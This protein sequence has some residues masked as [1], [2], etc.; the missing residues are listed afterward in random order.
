MLEEII[1]TNPA[2]QKI[3]DSLPTLSK[4][5]SPLV[6]IG[7]AGV[8]KSFFALHIHA[9]SRFKHQPHEYMNFSI[10]SDRIQRI[11]LFGAEPPE[12]TTHRRGILE[13]TSTV[14]LKHINCANPYLQNRLADSIQSMTTTRFGSKEALPVLCR[15]IFTF[16]NSLSAL[17]KKGE[18]TQT[19]FDVLSKCKTFHIP[20]L[21]DRK[22]DIPI[23]SE[24]FLKKFYNQLFSK[25]NGQAPIIR[26]LDNKKHLEPR[27][28]ETLINHAWQDNIRDLMAFLRNMLI[29]PYEYELHQTEKLEVMKMLIMM[30]N[31]NEF[32]LPN[33]MTIIENSVVNQAVQKYS[34]RQTKIALMLGLTDRTVR[35]L[36]TKH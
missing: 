21:H 25:F 22:E 30:E 8:G 1:G 24:Y 4:Q 11:D 17:L 33:S 18:L 23:L 3:R 28:A 29:F 35:R 6:F 15:L 9:L 14:I 32:S 20:A 13:N 10:L 19:L 16:R 7:E 36:L 5:S 12:L 26:G 34:G 31:G 2:I 27:L